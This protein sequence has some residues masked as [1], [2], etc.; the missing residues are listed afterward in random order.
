MK[1]LILSVLFVYLIFEKGIIDDFLI[2]HFNYNI[3]NSSKPINC[4]IKFATIGHIYSITKRTYTDFNEKK[5]VI[6]FNNYIDQLVKDINR[7]KLD[8]LVLLG[9]LTQYRNDDEW[10]VLK[11]FVKRLNTKVFYVPGN[12]DVD[13]E[14]AVDQYKKN[15]GYISSKKIINGCSFY[16]LNSNNLEK[17]DIN[18]ESYDVGAGL[19]LDRSSINLLRDINEDEFNMLFMHHNVYSAEIWHRNNLPLYSKKKI[20]TKHRGRY[21]PLKTEENWNNEVFP[22][23]KNKVR[24]VYS[25]DYHNKRGSVMIKD[26]ITYIANAFR[27]VEESKIAKQGKGPLAY[28]VTYIKDNVI[29]VYQRFLILPENRLVK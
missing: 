21:I 6:Y 14:I 15:I 23:I 13:E 29:T 11:K 2:K 27:Y 12:H 9:D 26:N 8:V 16:L 24:L 25:G 7:E 19:G 4:E 18:L 10:N 28:N 5:S 17:K 1:K 20:N 22:H 3:S